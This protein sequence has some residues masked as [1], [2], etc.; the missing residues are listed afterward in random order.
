LA[1]KSVQEKQLESLLAKEAAK[2]GAFT[3]GYVALY[4]RLLL[5]RGPTRGGYTMDEFL[6]LQRRAREERP[7]SIIPS[8]ERVEEF[9]AG[10]TKT[11]KPPDITDE[12]LTWI[13]GG[14]LRSSAPVPIAPVKT[15]AELAEELRQKQE[16]ERLADEQRKR[17]DAKRR[18]RERRQTIQQH[19]DRLP[20]L[21]KT[22]YDN[23][24]VRFTSDPSQEQQFD[25]FLNGGLPESGTFQAKD[26][27]GKIVTLT[28]QGQNPGVMMHGGYLR[29]S[30][31]EQTKLASL[32]EE[33][34][35]TTA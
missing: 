20:K 25:I 19:E 23:L 6:F 2:N 35:E 4:D 5:E 27:A 26:N 29:V 32:P 10:K 15:E 21:K 30:R 9:R 1:R 11:A 18:E 3:K 28:T 33:L 16:R 31:V 8:E 7:V 14:D 34:P 17:D 12:E 13:S 22:A 24:L